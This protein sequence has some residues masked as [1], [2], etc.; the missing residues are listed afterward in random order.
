M[1][2]MILA[3]GFGTRLT[4]LTDTLPKALIPVN[5]KAMIS[6]AIDAVIAAGCSKVVV[7]AHH[8]TELMEQHVDSSNYDCEVTL[9]KEKD[10]LGTGGGI[11]H[12]APWLNGPD[13]FLVHNVDIITDYDLKGFISQHRDSGALATLAVND[14]STSRAV[15]FDEKM[16]FLGKEVW[17][18]DG[19]VYPDS[20]RRCGFCG[21]HMI[22]AELFEHVQFDGFS[23]IFDLYRIAMNSGAMIHGQPFNGYWTDLGTVA[24][25]DDYEIRSRS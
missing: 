21:I 15:L 4:P 5:G 14:R 20:A 13:G 3:A 23:D 9:V 17:K 12:A 19:A 10:I 1:T 7:N 11:L 2:A 6:H 25:I 18:N 16:H 22:S 24:R 8:F